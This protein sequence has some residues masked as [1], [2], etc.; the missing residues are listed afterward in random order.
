MKK[1]DL[2]RDW[3]VEKYPTDDLGPELNGSVTFSTVM[4]GLKAGKDVYDIMGVGDSIVRE[5][6][7]SQ[8]ADLY[9]NGDYDKIYR[10]WL[11]N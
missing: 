10:A 5:R 8:L 7:F 2:I 3:Y 1:T 6:V 9:A 4:R 11:D